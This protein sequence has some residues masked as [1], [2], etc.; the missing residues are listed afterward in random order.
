MTIKHILV[1]G[2]GQMGAGIAQVAL[3]SGHRVTLV[4]V[5][6]DSLAKG[7]AGLE[8]GLSRLVE[9]GKLDAAAKAAA[10]GR[11]STASSVLD[12]KDVDVGKIGRAHV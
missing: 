8:K 2:A 1:I 10:L 12:V 11:L 6:A 4:D 5:S 7:K 3:S 9:K